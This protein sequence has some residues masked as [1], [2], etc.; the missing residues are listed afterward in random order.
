MNK[1]C[2]H[3]IGLFFAIAMASGAVAAPKPH[4]QEQNSQTLPPIFEIPAYLTSF[5]HRSC[6]VDQVALNKVTEMSN[7]WMANILRRAFGSVYKNSP[8]LKKSDYLSIAEIYHAALTGERVPTYS[9]TM[10]A[11]E[12]FINKYKEA[13][14]RDLNSVIAHIRIGGVFL[15]RGDA[16]HVGGIIRLPSLGNYDLD[17]EAL[18]VSSIGLFEESWGVKVVNHQIR[19]VPAKFYDGYFALLQANYLGAY[20]LMDS[21]G[22][23]IGNNIYDKRNGKMMLEWGIDSYQSYKKQVAEKPFSCSNSNLGGGAATLQ[24]PVGNIF[25]GLFGN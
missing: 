16:G 1:I 7:Y 5:Y 8:P 22:Q 4:A 14:D 6:Q 24:N 9:L 12:E 11:Q 25:K 18:N 15:L 13:I 3:L 23:V 21:R 19:N 10:G 2:Q 17:S 20:L